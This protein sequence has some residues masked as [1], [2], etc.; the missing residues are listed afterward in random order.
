MKLFFIIFGTLLFTNNTFG[1]SKDE[2]L[3]EAYL[4]YNSEK[5]SWHG[6]DIF[7][8][9]FPEKR[10]LI[11]GYLSYS[12][13]NQHSCIFF[14]KAENPNLLAKLTFNENFNIEQIKIDTISRKLNTL[15]KNL[16]TIRKIAL[17]EMNKDTLFKQYK[18][19]DLNP[20][21]LISNK[22]KKVFVLTGPQ[23]S[24]VVIF[25]NDY[26]LTFDKNNKIKTKKALHKNI[27]SIEYNAETKS[28]ITMHSHLKPTSNLIT[29]TDLCTI[30]LYEKYARWK[31]HIVV[32]KKNVSLWDCEKDVLLVMTKKAWEKTG[33]YK[34]KK[35]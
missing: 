20:I 24:G 17:A 25:G 15:E 18:N 34:T 28:D 4:L 13:D 32:S 30:M 5:A 33:K 19:T 12:E 7:L 14:D 26:L 8:E 11:G 9:K 31:Q 21:P 2:I 29:S 16:F 35:E 10:N 1:Q 6:T 22:E 27:I 3:T 23:I